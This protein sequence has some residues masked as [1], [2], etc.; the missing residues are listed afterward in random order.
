MT[1][2]A[3]GLCE[4][5]DHVCLTYDSDDVRLAT[6]AAIVRAGVTAGHKI[7][8]PT[9]ALP[10][11][12]VTDG[13]RARGI[14]VDVLLGSGQLEIGTAEGTYLTGGRLDIDENIRGWAGLCERSRAEGYTGLRVIGDMTW[15][16]D[17]DDDRFGALVRYEAEINKVYAEGY[18]MAFC[19]YDTRRFGQER[20]AAARAAHPSAAGAE[21]VTTE[22]PTLRMRRPHLLHLH[23]VGEAD[24]SN[25]AAIEAM[26]TILRDDA[27]R[28]HQ[29]AY[30]NVTGLRFADNTTVE[31]MLRIARSVPAGLSIVGCRPL[32]ATM[33]GLHGGAK[34]AGLRLGL[35]GS[36]PV[37]SD[38]IGGR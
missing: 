14:A 27:V 22:R 12:A 36:D 17:A 13:L 23:L 2:A 18:A 28:L 34:I 20:L 1:A 8:H 9:S 25:G 33:I 32:L 6:T 16:A 24:L 10:P 30:I 3:L 4:L 38:P 31:A 26:L 21:S 29:R 5:G 37:G 15:A 11:A 35:T 7:V 19:Q